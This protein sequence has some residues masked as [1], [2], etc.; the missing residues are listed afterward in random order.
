[1]QSLHAP[2]RRSIALLS[3]VAS[4]AIVLAAAAS[5][6]DDDARVSTAGAERPRPSLGLA[7]PVA[8]ETGRAGEELAVIDVGGR[9]VDDLDAPVIGRSLVVVDRRGTRHETATDEDGAFRAAQIA[10]PYDVLV[11]P[12]A[13]GAVI[14]P[15]VVLGLRR[16][17]P[18]LEVFER[19]GP[20]DRPASQPIR[21]GVK[22]P[23][24][25]SAGGACWVSVIS[26][27]PSGGGGTAGSY[28]AGTEHGLYELD[29][30]WR[31]SFTRPGESIEVHVLTGDAQY[32]EYAYAS[33]SRVAARPGEPTDVGVTVPTAVDSTEPVAV[34]GHADGL[35]EGYLWTLSA[36]LDLPGGAAIPLRYDWAATM[37]MRLPK[38]AGATWRVGAWAQHPQTPE[39]PYFHRSSQAWTGTLPFTA[40]NVSLDVPPAPETS[41]PAADGALS[42]AAEG[43]S[44]EGRGPALASLVLVDLA[45]GRQL[46][47][48]LTAEAGISVERLDALGL[49]R[50]ARGEHVLDLT[51][52]PGAT[53]VD[54]VTHPS[55]SQRRRRFESHVAG[56]TTYQRFRF[57]VTP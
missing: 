35:P 8:P 55:A 1:M 24:C 53:T 11:A 52:T 32:T 54:E 47:R 16:S 13:A 19:E 27:S 50:L 3:S 18:W 34:D 38:L 51:T 57:T 28:E 15:L 39:R 46:F 25:R 9:V 44:W 29:H 21:I 40:T 6:A 36:H 45:R 33:V 5:C 37:T 48:L 30:A 43:L 31:E 56:A 17:D 14:T 20:L 22:L 42:R 2:V 10:P 23:P 4:A 26:A 12:A 41:R 7:T 49:D